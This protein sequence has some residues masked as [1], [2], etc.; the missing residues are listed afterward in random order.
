MDADWIIT[1]F[2]LIDTVLELFDHRVL[3]LMASI[4]ASFPSVLSA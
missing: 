2:V 3:P 1:V 4:A